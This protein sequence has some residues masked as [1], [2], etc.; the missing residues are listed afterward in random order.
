MAQ[1]YYNAAEAAK[2]LGVSPADINQMVLRK[3]LYGY[4]DGSD[5]KF[6]AEDVD[7]VAEERGVGDQ[8]DSG[9]NVLASEIELGQSDPGL[10]GTVIGADKNRSSAESDIHLVD[11]DVKLVPD[12]PSVSDLNLLESGIDLAAPNQ[13]AGTK[14]SD[15]GSKVSQFEDLDMTLDHD[16]TLEEGSDAAAPNKPAKAGDSA[17]DLSGMKLKDDDV[18]LGG[19]GT[20][21][22]ISIGGDSGISLVDPADSGLSLEA[23]LSLSSGEESLELGEDDLLGMASDVGS[24]SGLKG[25]DD[26]Q[27][28]PMDDLS[29]GDDSESGSQVIALD[30]EGEGDEAATMVATSGTPVAAMLDEDLGADPTLAAMPLAATAD[31]G[32]AS[33]EDA[34]A[35][36]AFGSSAAALPEAPYTIWNIVSLVLVSM[37]LILAGMMMYEL[38]LNMWGFDKPIRPGPVDSWL[39]DTI[40]GWFEK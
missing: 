38:L 6:K 11:S 40:L 19:S 27:L 5:W 26:F 8:G 18:V 24:G 3:E 15:V 20:G 2:I 4:R 32:L 25:E 10:S 30:T 17:V 16:L 35:M 21:S 34:L 36:G 33:P 37:L 14:K 28:T 39:M 1:K 22:D 7:R 9:D 31:L 23:P 13:P 12:K 29:D